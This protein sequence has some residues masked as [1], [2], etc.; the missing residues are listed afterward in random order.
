MIAY[1]TERLL[2]KEGFS[3][4]DI[5]TVAVPKIPDRLAL[6]SSG[7]LAAGTM[8]EPVASLLVLQ[9]ATVIL[10]DN[11]Y[12]ELSYSTIAF[13]T[14]TLE[15]QPQA[16]R[17]FL[18]AIEQAVTAI[19]SNPALYEQTLIENNILPAPLQGKFAVPQFVRASVPSPEQYQDVYQWALA[20]NMLSEDVT[21]E[22]SVNPSFLP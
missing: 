5:V 19:N 1:L 21:Y 18:A 11:K 20:K 12:P 17:D 14:E 8:P 16:V 9:G 3:E 15:K 13:R 7:E 4:N 6:L 10:A 2:Q 22:T